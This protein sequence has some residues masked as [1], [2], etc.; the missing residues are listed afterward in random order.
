M[1]L[2]SAARTTR[3]I[4]R[5]PELSN[6]AAAIREQMR[7]AVLDLRPHEAPPSA[8]LPGGQRAFCARCLWNWQHGAWFWDLPFES[9]AGWRCVLCCVLSFDEAECSCCH[10]P[11]EVNAILAQRGRW[12]R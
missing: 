5:P 2:W 12:E 1:R 4:Y 3:A 8:R 10:L 7:G 6:C 11:R 9:A